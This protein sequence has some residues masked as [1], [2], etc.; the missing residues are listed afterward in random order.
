M[1]ARQKWFLWPIAALAAIVAVIL[2]L[3]D[4]NWLK[5]P[6]EDRISA[7][8]GRQFQIAGDLDVDLSL[9][10]RIKVTD[11]RLANP[12]WASHEPMLV[13]PR[14]EAVIDLLALLRGE[15]R[16]PE[17]SVTEPSLRLETRPDGPPNW[18]FMRAPSLPPSIP[19]IGRLQIANASIDYLEHGSGRRVAANLTEMTGSTGGPSGKMAL[20]ATGT[21]A[22]EPLDLQL[23]GPPA[24][25]LEAAARS[26]PLALSLRL[27]ESDLAGD[28]MLELGKEVPAIGATLHSDRV[29][30]TDL[31]K[32]TAASAASAPHARANAGKPRF[33]FDQLPALRVDIKYVIGQLEGPDLHLQNVDL[34]AG[35]ANGLPTLALSGK[36]TFKD[37]PL[38]LDV[39]VG[40]AG[41]NQ[42]EGTPYRVNAEIEAGQT[43]VTAQGGIDRPELLQGVHVNFQTT[44]GDATDLLRR[45]GLPAPE[46]PQFQA[47]GKL[48]REGKVWQLDDGDL[49]IGESAVSGR[50]RADLSGPRPFIAADLE[51]SRLRMTDILPQAAAGAA[52]NAP[53]SPLIKNGDINP[54]A[55]PPVDVD[56]KLRASHVEASEFRFDRLD[57]DLQLRDRVAVIDGGGRWPVPRAAARHSRSM[58]EPRTA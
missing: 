42:K 24:A 11:V 41:A 4:W 6:L 3:F 28:L 46:L 49:R 9:H 2:V 19:E 5:G 17:V 45:L 15:I 44:S 55:L 23:S 16:L 33:D 48:S 58:P 56:F 26:Y 30:T 27:G 10:P 20:A 53:D 43:K 32:L 31:A 18:R 57:L 39:R 29:K 34:Q 21:V 14:A 1:S 7:R 36:G 50:V 35:L 37:E 47:T 38:V 40:P 8:L 54:E 51:S 25:Q 52:I 22:G 12:P 13:V